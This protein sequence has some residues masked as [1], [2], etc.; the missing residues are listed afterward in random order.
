MA[1]QIV[2]SPDPLS[3]ASLRF[4]TSA[5][6]MLVESSALRI[7][8]QEL[9]RYCRG[10]INGRSFL[11]AGHR[12]AGKTTLVAKAFM[13]VRRESEKGGMLRPLFIPLHGPSLFP[14]APVRAAADGAKDDAKTKTDAQIA[15]EQIT[16]GLHRAVAREFALQYRERVRTLAELRRTPNAS[17]KWLEAARSNRSKSDDDPL[18]SALNDSLPAPGVLDGMIARIPPERELFELAGQFEAELQ[19]GPSSQRLRDFWD[20]AHALSGGVLFREGRAPHVGGGPGAGY[21]TPAVPPGLFPNLIDVHGQGTRELVALSGVVEAYR[22]ISGDYKRTEGEKSS[23]TGTTERT[24]GFSADAKELTSQIVSLLTGGLTATALAIAGTK[25]AMTALGGIATALGAGLVFKTTSTRKRERSTSRESQF[26]YDLSVAT[27]DRILPILIERLRTAGLAPVFVVDELD[28][29]KELSTKLVTMVHHLKKLVAENAF[30]CFLTNRSYYEEMLA[31]GSGLPYPVEYTYYTNRLFVV[32]SAEDIEQYLRRRLTITPLEEEANDEAVARHSRE[33][34]ASAVLRWAL[35]HRSQLHAVDLQRE[36]LIIRDDDGASVRVKPEVITSARRNLIDLTFQVGIELTLAQDEVEQVLQ[37]RPE[38][39]RLVYDALYYLSRQW[40]GGAEEVD[41]SPSGQTAFM[42]YLERRTGREEERPTGTAEPATMLASVNLKDADFLYRQV[43]ILA[44]FLSDRGGTD[45]SGNPWRTGRIAEWNRARAQRSLPVVEPDIIDALL[46]ENRSSLLQGDATRTGFY[47][48]RHRVAGQGWTPPAVPDRTATQPAP[49]SATG[50][51]TSEVAPQPVTPEPT[52][53]ETGQAGSSASWEKQAEFIEAFAET[54]RRVTRHESLDEG[55][56][57]RQRKASVITLDAL[58]T[59]YRILSQSPTASIALKAISN[60]RDAVARGSGAQPN[61][62]D[63]FQVDQFY[64]LIHRN[65]E[66]IARA[67]ILGA[68]VGRAVTNRGTDRPTLATDQRIAAGLN[69]IAR[70]MRFADK[71]EADLAIALENL[72]QVM[73][74]AYG[75]IFERRLRE[76]VDPWPDLVAFRES[77]RM[78]IQAALDLGEPPSDAVEPA[79]W[80]SLVDRLDRWVRTDELLEPDLNELLAA[81]ADIGPT[82]VIDF[83]P[84]YLTLHQWTQTLL[85][86][87]KHAPWLTLFAWHALGFSTTQVHELRLLT[88]WA[89][90]PDTFTSPTSSTNGWP[91]P[92]VRTHRVVHDGVLLRKSAPATTVVML[93]RAR[94]PLTA[95]WRPAADV[96]T[97][98]LTAVQFADLLAPAPGALP[99]EL[100][101]T[102]ERVCAVEMDH[103]LGRELYSSQLP[104]IQRLLRGYAKL[105][106]AYAADRGRDM[107]TPSIVAPSDITAVARRAIDANELLQPNRPV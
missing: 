17:R 15:L 48:F 2:D 105:V 101:L 35:R 47:R 7:L 104:E 62:D 37:D 77:V 36:I 25:P 60:L 46:V 80:S 42:A 73:T 99:L 5:D 57:A 103:E 50:R 74:K 51:G 38:F 68:I 90:L 83:D 64:Q 30:F 54:V 56:P 9:Q 75:P 78:G 52:A 21:E 65:A 33:T 27:L 26:V 53:Q 89:R 55:I 84:R 95:Q 58:A 93:R 22:R 24:A 20:R 106:Y 8:R 61:V 98:V 45:P 10:M 23:D 49:E 4:D 14:T 91:E 72:T 107:K 97:L 16:L 44:D 31:N 71:R 76:A 81:A 100:P 102:N 39:R 13:D 59:N 19:E 12:G 94:S 82:T 96:A 70:A 41:L 66:Q 67:I 28:K 43:G 11:I 88:H 79:A 6:P 92:L 40:L 85:D 1:I 32:F 63:T 18:D 34:A 69:I 86:A 3:D 29:V 87:R